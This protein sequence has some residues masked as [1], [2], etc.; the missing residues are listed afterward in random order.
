MAIPFR[1]AAGTPVGVRL[2]ESR[3]LVEGNAVDFVPGRVFEPHDDIEALERFFGFGRLRDRNAQSQLNLMPRSHR[4]GLIV[5]V[6]ERIKPA[7]RKH[8]NAGVEGLWMQV[9]HGE[10]R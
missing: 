1:L 5:A 2:A 6:G 4:L 3:Y 9:W 8:T 7:A 10:N